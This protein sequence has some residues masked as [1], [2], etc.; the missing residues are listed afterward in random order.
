[1]DSAK[2]ERE[3]RRGLPSRVLFDRL[4]E[5]LAG[6]RLTSAADCLDLDELVARLADPL[7]CESCPRSLTMSDEV[8]RGRCRT[9]RRGKVG[10]G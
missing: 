3:A 6:A 10:H 4:R 5:G 7:G 9:C 2:R 8:A 1:L